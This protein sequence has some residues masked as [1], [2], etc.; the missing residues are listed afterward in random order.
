MQLGSNV[1]GYRS[2]GSCIDGRVEPDGSSGVEQ[3]TS[4][5]CNRQVYSFSRSSSWSTSTT[6]L[7]AIGP[8]FTGS[9]PRFQQ[10]F[11]CTALLADP[12]PHSPVLASRIPQATISQHFVGISS[13]L[14]SAVRC[15]HFSGDGF[16]LLVYRPTF[17]Y[18]AAVKCASLRQ[19]MDW[20]LH[21]F[22]H[23][24]KN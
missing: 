7:Q 10:P 23:R 9:F 19:G 21:G 13:I 16:E 8:F 22:S 14:H 6:L 1:G 20:T 3:T 5:H 11:V 12:H 2:S 17:I 24:P 15:F 18:C 4:S